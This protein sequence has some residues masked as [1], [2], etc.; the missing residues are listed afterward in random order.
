MNLNSHA[1]IV[2]LRPVFWQINYLWLMVNLENLTARDWWQHERPKLVK[3]KW[4]SL[5]ADEPTLCTACLWGEVSSSIL[6][7]HRK[8]LW[9]THKDKLYTVPVKKFSLHDKH[10][11][12]TW[13]E[14]RMNRHVIPAWAKRL[15]S[16]THQKHKLYTVPT[17]KSSLLNKRY[18]DMLHF[19]MKEPIIRRGSIP[20]LTKRLL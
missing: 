19:Y 1:M 7:R 2:T 17:M 6:A 20:V 16:R 15:L 12:F 5:F 3:L 13:W 9:R 11:I 4:T 10:N 8:L 14:A 18:H